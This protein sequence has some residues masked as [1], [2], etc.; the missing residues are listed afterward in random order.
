MADIFKPAPKDV[1]SA[2]EY[3]DPQGLVTPRR[4]PGYA[5]K[6]VLSANGGS[7]GD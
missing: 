6:L 7:K 5:A 2:F 1:N 3:T 4:L